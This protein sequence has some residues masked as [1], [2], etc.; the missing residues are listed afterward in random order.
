MNFNVEIPDAMADQMHLDAPQ[1]Q[2]LAL[3]TFAVEGYR[4]GELSRGRVSELLDLSFWETE[5]LLKERGCGLG[6]TFE[7]HQRQVE[8]LKKF[9]GR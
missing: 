4:K 7:E 9:L 6:V 1:V 5:A 3:E 2:R 8:D